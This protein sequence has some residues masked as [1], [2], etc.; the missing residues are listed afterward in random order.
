MERAK[1]EEFNHW[2]TKEQVDPELALN[3]KRD[4]YQIIEAHISKKFITALVR[5]R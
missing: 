5:L 3:F 1:L 2:L 4:A